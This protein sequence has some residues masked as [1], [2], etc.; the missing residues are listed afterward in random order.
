MSDW[1]IVKMSAADVA[2]G[3]DIQL[4]RDF[5]IVFY[6]IGAPKDVALF[7]RSLWETIPTRFSSSTSLRRRFT[8]ART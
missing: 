8:H 4:Q 5:G 3:R 7:S 2:N 1:R 6:T